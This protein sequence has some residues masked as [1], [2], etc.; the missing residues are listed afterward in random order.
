MKVLSAFFRATLL[1]GVSASAIL[2]IGAAWA[3]DSPNA[4]ETVVVTGTLIRSPDATSPSPLQSIDAQFI[5]DQGTINIQDALQ[6]NPSFGAPGYSRAV[7]NGD[8]TNAGTAT[9][10][11]RNL[12]ANRTLVLIDGMRTVAGVP[13][14]AQVDLAMV[15][16]DFIERVDVLT[17]GAS[18]LYGSDA[19]AGVVNIIYKKN[20]EGLIVDAQGGVSQEGDDI[21]HKISATGGYNFANGRGNFMV[22]ASWSNEGVVRASDRWFSNDDWYSAGLLTSPKDPT[23]LFVRTLNRSTVI[24]GGTTAVGGVNYTFDNSGNAVVWNIND[25]S[26]RF[27]RSA[28]GASRAIASPVNR[29]SFATRT[30]YEVSDKLT[31]FLEGEYGHTASRSYYEP[32]PLVANSNIIGVGTNLNVENYVINPTTLQVVKVRNPYVP[33]V[34]YN[35]ATDTNGD[36]LKDIAFSKR[37]TEFGNRTTNIDRQ[38]FRIAFGAEGHL[39]NDWSYNVY[40]TYGRSELSALMTGLYI[41]SNLLNA[42]DAVTDIYDLNHNGSTTDVI[43]ADATARAYGC[44]P[45]DLFGVGNISKAAL[46]YVKGSAT[47]NSLQE[48]KVASANVSGTVFDLPAGPLQLAAGAEYRDESS[49]HIFDPL[50]N[51]HE[52]GYVQENNV[53]R[54][55]NVKE[56]FAE[57][58]VPI[59]ADMPMF[60]KLS[61]RAAAR[62]S[63]YSTVGDFWAYNGGVEW[64]PIDDLLIRGVYAHAV[65]APNIGELYAPSTAGIATIV[66]PCNGIKLTDTS[67][68]AKNCLKNPGVVANANANG[69]TATFIQTDFQGVQQVSQSNPDIH[70]EMANTWTFGAVYTPQQ[71]PGLVFTLDYYNIKLSDAIASAP[72]NT[73]LNLCYQQGLQA[74]CD[75]ITRRT[76]ASLPYSA[77]SVSQIITGLVNSGGEWTKGIDFTTHY[78]TEL[79]GGV[80]SVA[81]SYTR[82]LD[83]AIIPLQGQAVQKQAGSVGYPHNKGY[84]TLGYDNGPWGI[85]LTGQFIGASQLDYTWITQNF[86]TNVDV[87]N[88]KIDPVFYTDINLKYLFAD[89]YEF[90]FGVKNLFNVDPPPLWGG[91]PGQVGDAQTDSALYDTIGRRFYLGV[92][93]QF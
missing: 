37:V 44:Q 89:T 63:D 78:S 43:C 52:N 14:T 92:R 88:F 82:L 11:L 46:N 57:V 34:I 25:E 54:G 55:I 18:S 26:T 59:L 58:N 10:N 91:L 24:P 56:A 42:M 6:I 50:S 66:D 4:V 76:T 38:Q 67:T 72:T 15:P 84:I 22:N 12:G 83:Q 32:H 21:S 87:K 9:V 71:L 47:Q 51:A 41:Q 73:I 64:K 27:N 13:G 7:S 49:R 19:I 23:Q 5:Q 40:F 20:F 45:A 53:I 81:V 35:N 93:A 85:E 48:L 69:G 70:Q 28:Y 62:N 74:F 8:V 90:Y 60:E 77:G 65:R 36:G 29:L 16:T 75:A 39:S 86:G 61:L 79:A 3:A 1:G 17:G 33:D 30:S 2:T 80:T 68:I 31:V